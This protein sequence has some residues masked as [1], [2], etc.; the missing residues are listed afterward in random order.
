MMRGMLLSEWTKLA[1]DIRKRDNYTCQVCGKK[2]DILHV[3][4]IIPY[5]ISRNNNPDNL[6]TLCGKCHLKKH[7]IVLPIKEMSYITTKKNQ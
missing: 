4:H 1:E 6:E 3:H 5:R 2:Y 7:K